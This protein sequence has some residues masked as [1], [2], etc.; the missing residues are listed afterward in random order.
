MKIPLWAQFPNIKACFP[1]SMSSLSCQFKH[2]FRQLITD[3]FSY[4]LEHGFPPSI[5]NV[6]P[7]CELFPTSTNKCS[8]KFWHM[9]PINI[10][11]FSYQY[12]HV[13]H[14]DD[15]VSGQLGCGTART[16][17]VLVPRA[18]STVGYCVCCRVFH[19]VCFVLYLSGFNRQNVFMSNNYLVMNLNLF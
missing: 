13:G 19:K 12:G 11:I 14:S 7:V 6:L 9:F 17:L 8:Y 2:V 18:A 5:A 1:I 4:Q 10:N 3:I 15:L 16:L